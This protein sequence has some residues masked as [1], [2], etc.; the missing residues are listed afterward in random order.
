LDVS[1]P[2]G[3]RRPGHPARSTDPND[4]TNLQAG[5]HPAPAM[6]GASV[7]TVPA[8]SRRTPTFDE[9]YREIERLPGR[10]GPR[11]GRLLPGCSSTSWPKPNGSYARTRPSAWSTRSTRS[12]P[13]AASSWLGR[14]GTSTTATTWGAT[15]CGKA[16]RR[17]ERARERR[18]GRRLPRRSCSTRRSRTSSGGEERPQ[19]HPPPQVSTSSL[20]RVLPL[21]SSC[22]LE[23]ALLPASRHHSPQSL[24]SIDP[25]R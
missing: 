17:R 14:R 21:K 4:R 6:S 16:R 10:G 5:T 12:V 19:L 7:L 8:A 20:P 25:D 22:R 24:Q 23:K 11:T 2:Q 18:A 13:C 15:S 3:L 1:E 9:L